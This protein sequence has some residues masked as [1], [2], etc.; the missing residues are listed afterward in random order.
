MKKNQNMGLLPTKILLNYESGLD[1][2]L[3]TKKIIQSFFIFLFIYLILH[4]LAEACTLRVFWFQFY[5]SN[6]TL[7][8]TTTKTPVL[9]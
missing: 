2:S 8:V 6:F 5:F 9:T 4:A 7:S 3:E 1:H